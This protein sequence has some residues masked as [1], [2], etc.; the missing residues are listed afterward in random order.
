MGREELVIKENIQ[1]TMTQS[2]KRIAGRRLLMT[3]AVM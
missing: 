1:A 2:P 3:N